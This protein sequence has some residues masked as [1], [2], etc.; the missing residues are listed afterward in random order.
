MRHNFAFARYP[1][2]VAGSEK[3]EQNESDSDD[4][5]DE[6]FERYRSVSKARYKDFSI[7]PSFKT[8][9]TRRR[10]S[11]SNISK[12]DRPKT[13]SET[14]NLGICGHSVVGSSIGHVRNQKF[15]D[16]E[17]KPVL[18]T[19]LPM[20]WISVR[21]CPARTPRKP[22]RYETNEQRAMNHMMTRWDFECASKTLAA[23]E[24]SRKKAINVPDWARGRAGTVFESRRPTKRAKVISRAMVDKDADIV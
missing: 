3:V 21:A 11:V 7:K 2:K 10:R 24:A 4:S 18:N 12:V 15:E 13:S 6:A 20:D 19:T 22:T 14:L 1:R 17:E 23:I 9:V 16:F 8:Q 5:I